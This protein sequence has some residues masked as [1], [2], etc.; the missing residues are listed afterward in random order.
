MIRRALKEEFTKFIDILASRF[1][2]LSSRAIED[3]ILQVECGE[4]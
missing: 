3:S 4:K 1:W 2:P